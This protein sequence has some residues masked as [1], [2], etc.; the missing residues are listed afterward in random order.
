MKSCILDQVGSLKKDFATREILE[1][2]LYDEDRHID[3]IEELKGQIS[4]MALPL[5]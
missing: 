2:I 5:F 4:Y 1:G 3:G